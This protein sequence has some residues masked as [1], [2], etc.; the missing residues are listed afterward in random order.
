MNVMASSR[1]GSLPQGDV[2]HCGS[3]P[4]RESGIKFNT[5]VQ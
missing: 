4:A 1:A 5:Y 2:F 3:E